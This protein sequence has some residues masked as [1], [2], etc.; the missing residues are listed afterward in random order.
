M[1]ESNVVRC[2]LVI[3]SSYGSQKWFGAKS[4][5][6]EENTYRYTPILGIACI[7]VSI[8]VVRAL[9]TH[10]GSSNANNKEL[11]RTY[12]Y[13][14]CCVVVVVVVRDHVRLLEVIRGWHFMP[15]GASL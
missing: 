1:G 14:S 2:F 3:G 4:G 11:L 15:D 12:M 10:E 8:F 6:R 7:H 9:A 13:V 5:T